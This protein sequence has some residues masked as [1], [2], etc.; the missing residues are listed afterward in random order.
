MSEEV[1]VVPNVIV[2]H[3]PEGILYVDEEDT[4]TGSILG[5][6]RWMRRDEAE[7][8]PAF[9]QIIPQVLIEADGHLWGMERLTGSSEARLHHQWTCTV[10][11]HMNPVDL[12]G[13]PL[14]MDTLWN[15]LLREMR[16]EI[17]LPQDLAL[18]MGFQGWLVDSTTAVSRVHLGAMFLARVTSLP[19]AATWAVGEPTKLAGHWIRRAD[20][21]PIQWDS[22]SQAM[23]QWWLSRED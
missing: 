11:G 17:T 20:L 6:A 22:W 10:G 18:E 12:D 8:N 5:N 21:R 16:E 23:V 19:D 1:L 7:E 9:R 15:G 13:H 2:A 14:Q 3:V 4:L